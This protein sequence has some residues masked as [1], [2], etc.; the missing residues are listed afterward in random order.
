MTIFFQMTQN[1]LHFLGNVLLLFHHL[2]F[3]NSFE[4]QLKFKIKRLK[5]SRHL[6]KQAI[7][8]LERQIKG[9]ILNQ[10]EKIK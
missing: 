5:K 10:D 8:L 1:I 2:L 4:E 6:L 9:E 3:N 7:I